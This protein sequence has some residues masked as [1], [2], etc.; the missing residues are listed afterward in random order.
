[1]KVARTIISVVTAVMLAVAFVG[2]G[3]L[4]CTVP[5]VT[6]GLS[7]AF[8]RDDISPFS[9]AQLVKVAEATRDFS[10]GSHSE[11]ALYQAIYEVDME[12][13]RSVVET[14]GQVPAAFPA[15]ELVQDPDNLGQYQR[16]F[17]GASELYCFSSDTVVHLDDCYALASTANPL[18][19]GAALLAVAG[20]VFTG[21]Q[22]RRRAVGAVLLG[23][24]IGVLVVFVAL[25]AWAVVDFNGFFAQFHQLFFSQGNWTF[26]YDSLLI[27]SLSEP[28]WAGMG[29]VWLLVAL[30]MA[31][32]SIAVGRKL[33]K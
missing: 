26:P 3:F 15:L 18:L 23:A 33:R 10:F 32:A 16:A 28:F 14:G 21:V 5:P 11:L 7:N 27:C 20:L 24:G 30:V 2:A 9:R 17:R 6:Q 31:C 8:A 25:G 29:A 13:Q 19:A 1:M 22:G 4:V 12:Y